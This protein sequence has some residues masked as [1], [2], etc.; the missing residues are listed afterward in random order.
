MFKTIE[1]HVRQQVAPA[2]LRAEFRQHES[3]PCARSA[4]WYSRSAS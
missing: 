1:A 2:A 3:S 4:C